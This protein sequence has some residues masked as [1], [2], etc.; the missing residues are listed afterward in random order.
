MTIWIC[1]WRMNTLVTSQYQPRLSNITK[2]FS[3]RISQSHWNIQINNFLGYNMFYSVQQVSCNFLFL[4]NERSYFEVMKFTTGTDSKQT[5]WNNMQLY[6]LC[7]HTQYHDTKVYATCF[8]VYQCH[9]THLTSSWNLGHNN[10]LV[11]HNISNT[12]LEKQDG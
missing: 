1:R 6:I 10:L 3:R 12:Q 11:V 8:T 9:S 2:I 4:T 7:I 5:V